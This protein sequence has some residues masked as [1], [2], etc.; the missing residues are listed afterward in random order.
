[1][2]SPMPHGVP[3]W[4]Y[5]SYVREWPSRN[6][7]GVARAPR[8]HGI[9]PSM[10]LLCFL[11]HSQTTPSLEVS[12]RFP[13]TLAETR[14]NQNPTSGRRRP[15]VDHGEFLSHHIHTPQRASSSPP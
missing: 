3:P 4:A 13:W 11:T 9:T 14:K 6:V 12:G 15:L 7:S 10:C 2:K 5:G 8:S 1:M